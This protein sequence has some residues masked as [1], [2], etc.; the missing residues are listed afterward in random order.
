MPVT[1]LG[2]KQLLRLLDCG[3]RILLVNR[4][5]T[6]GEAR[7]LSAAFV[8]HFANGEAQ[9]V[10]AFDLDI[11]PGESVTFDLDR[12][13]ASSV[14][15]VEVL[16]RVLADDGASMGEAYAISRSLED[17]GLRVAEFGVIDRPSTLGH[18]ESIVPDAQSIAVYAKPSG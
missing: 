7:I 18:G 15:A 17:S 8:R 6:A 14:V 9:N 11:G 13:S 2:E 10:A 12:P 3:G 16:L 4:V 1:L 5:E